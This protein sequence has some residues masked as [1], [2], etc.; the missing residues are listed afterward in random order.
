MTHARTHRVAVGLAAAVLLAAVPLAGTATARA[1]PDREDDVV[2]FERDVRYI[3]GAA[4]RTP[5]ADTP[6]TQDLFNFT[7]IGLGVNW[8]QWSS[9]SA[10]ASARAS[11]KHTDVD[12]TFTGLIPGG[13]YSVFWGTLE[14]D[15]EHPLCRGVER[16]LPVVSDARKKQRPDPSS[17]VAGPDGTAQFSGRAGANL[18]DGIWLSWYSIVYHFDG[19]AYHPFPNRGEWLTHDGEFGCHA[20]YGEDAMRQL[21]VF[22]KGY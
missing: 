17:F 5:D 4:L 19:R 20:S 14:P 9:A 3:H 18:V 15:S 11:G 21:L 22:Q 8:G 1:A 7:G 2:V 10:T 13:V 6:P 16:T 12:L